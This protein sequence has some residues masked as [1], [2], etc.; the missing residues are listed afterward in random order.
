MSTDEQLEHHDRHEAPHGPGRRDPFGLGLPR[1]PDWETFGV[2][3]GDETPG[4]A[5]ASLASD[6]VVEVR[7][8]G[9]V[10]GLVGVAAAG[11]GLAWLGRALD[12]GGALTWSVT[13]VLAVVA[14][15]HLTAFVDARVPL[16]VLDSHGVRMRLGRTWQ[17]LPWEAVEQVELAPRTSWWRD[18]RLVVEPF[19]ADEVVAA[20][21]RGARWQAWWS[22]RW[23]GGAFALPLGLSTRVRGADDLGLA[24]ERVVDPAVD[25]VVVEPSPPVTVDEVPEPVE[26]AASA[27]VVESP[28]PVE[29]V[30]VEPD[31]PDAPDTPDTPDAPRPSAADRLE[32][33][34]RVGPW[35]A[36]ALARA[37]EW[38][39][40]RRDA[41]D[42][43]DTGADESADDSAVREI[44]TT[45]VAQAEVTPAPEPTATPAAAR[46]ARSA[47]RAEIHA[48]TPQRPA[49]GALPEETV[50]LRRP[51]DDDLA[52]YETAAPTAYPVVVGEPEPVREPVVGQE[53]AA[54]R[55][56]LGLS[57]DQVAERTRIRPHVIEAIE[58]DDFE[59]CGGD[60]YARGH[61]RTLARVL[62]VDGDEAVE[63]YDATY[64]AAPIDARRVF[65]AE[66]ATVPGGSLR[67][68]RGGP[69]WS[70]L[71]AAVMA[72]VVLWSAAQMLFEGS[73]PAEEAT[74]G[75][76][77]SSSVVAPV[78][79][80]LTA[81]DSPVA[82]TV[83]DGAG[84]IVWQG[85]L[86]AG[87]SRT[88][89]AAPPVRVSASDGALS[90]AVDGGSATP[91]G[92]AGV[93]VQRS[94]TP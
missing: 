16:A 89:P 53:Y 14:L 42:G 38:R 90:A 58:V 21:D 49:R 62:G 22:R 39:P 43:A 86:A 25:V 10:T 26:P 77:L 7:R 85:D 35:A 34:R 44:A 4:G 55:R 17:G 54:A 3:A 45:S 68:T 51:A 69:N 29:P 88:V 60:F 59:P 23:Y 37:A 12:G 80:V 40:A 81:P 66:L 65:E 9:L 52:A 31:A 13:A 56:R 64:A 67:A 8:S 2:V 50:L 84:E 48:E 83:R 61:L 30:S 36:A 79:V 11:L 91:L 24:L 63:T 18:G 76:G 5:G 6:E 73:S 92:E 70:V 82:V 57:V 94:L 87:E 20:L 71:V 41:D 47:V 19:E 72:L 32:A 28:A 93:A 33:V 27:A 1:R 78:D 15:T 46:A 74:G 75:A